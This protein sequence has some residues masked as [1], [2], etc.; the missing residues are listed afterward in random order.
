MK[1]SLG[2]IEK[3]PYAVHMMTFLWHFILKAFFLFPFVPV[4]DDG[5]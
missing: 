4:K 1:S 3:E 5:L 2:E